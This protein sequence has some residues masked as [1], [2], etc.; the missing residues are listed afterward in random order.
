MSE[1]A[2]LTTPERRAAAKIARQ[3]EVA[4]LAVDDIL[5]PVWRRRSGRVQPVAPAE[6]GQG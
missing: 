3:K 1:T 6:D 4:R 5:D 2:T